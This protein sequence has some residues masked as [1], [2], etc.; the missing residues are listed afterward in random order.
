MDFPYQKPSSYW[1]SPITLCTSAQ[2]ALASRRTTSPRDRERNLS[3]LAVATVI[4]GASG[5]DEGGERHGSSM[6]ITY[7]DMS[8]GQ[9]S[10]LITINRG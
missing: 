9:Y 10:W 5:G 4:G 7:I 2:V 6:V 3:P 1:W 8:Y